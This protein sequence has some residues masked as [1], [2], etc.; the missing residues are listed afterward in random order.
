MDYMG[1]Y[2]LHGY[3]RLFGKDQQMWAALQTMQLTTLDEW[4]P[5]CALLP[6][7]YTVPE[8]TFFNP[9]KCA[10]YM[11][12]VCLRVAPEGTF[13]RDEVLA[14]R[15]APAYSPL[16]DNTYHSISRFSAH[17]TL[18]ELLGRA[19]L[20]D[21]AVESIQPVLQF[22]PT[23]SELCLDAKLCLGRCH[24]ASGQQR[25]AEAV[26]GEAL[27]EAQRTQMLLMQYRAISLL[28]KH[29]LGDD[30]RDDGGP[31]EG[32]RQRAREGQLA[33][34]RAAL[35]GPAELLEALG[36]GAI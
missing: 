11:A 16:D 2:G 7:S 18:G 34:L 30:G 15:S 29:G 1:L 32:Q 10:Y 9:E 19:G 36:A 24:A 22:A 3:A 23:N 27:A 28:R 6:L 12:L 17:C 13:D 35:Q 20:Y 8:G 26:L 25:E 21:E 31:Q 14:Q 33:E 5:L 4:R